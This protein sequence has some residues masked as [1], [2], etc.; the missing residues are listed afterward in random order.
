MPELSRRKR[1]GCLWRTISL[2]LAIGKTSAAY[3]AYIAQPADAATTRRGPDHSTAGAREANC[4]YPGLLGR[5]MAFAIAGHHAGLADGKDLERRLDKA[6]YAIESYAG[7]KAHSGEPP[8]PKSLEPTRPWLP[9]HANPGFSAA[10]LT[11]MLFSC[12]V[13]ADFL[14]TEKFYADAKEEPKRQGEYAP[15][16]TLRSRLK[17]Y[18]GRLNAS[19]ADT[20][21]N[22]LRARVLDHAVHKATL[23]PGLFTLT[24]PT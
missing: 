8:M 21:V 2:T 14:E 17:V 22:A 1:I 9:G 13:D 6:N 5:M 19:A 24:V 12:L 10:F 20:P 11:R 23:A 3:Q 7:W 4:V 18:M 16:A 15:L